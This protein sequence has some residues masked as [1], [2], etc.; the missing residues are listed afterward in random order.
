MCVCVI[1]S[2]CLGVGVSVAAN[3]LSHPAD[4]ETDGKFTAG[5]DLSIPSRGRLPQSLS[6]LL[7]PGRLHLPPSVPLLAP[8]LRHVC[9]CVIVYRDLLRIR[10][11]KPICRGYPRKVSL[12][13]CREIEALPSAA[14]WFPPHLL[15]LPLFLPP[16]LWRVTAPQ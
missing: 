12:F 4:R 1:A 6:P 15:F 10:D 11:R 3:A 16:S 7:L 5:G 8:P 14:L 2:A 13:V 9:L